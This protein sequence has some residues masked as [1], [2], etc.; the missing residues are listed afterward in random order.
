MVAGARC[1]PLPHQL[2]RAS[3]PTPAHWKPAAC[4]E[5]ASP[6]SRLR[7]AG[8]P[9]QVHWKPADWVKGTCPASFVRRAGRGLARFRRVRS[10]RGFAPGRLFFALA[11][12]S[13]ALALPSFAP[14]QPWQSQVLATHVAA[15][16]GAAVLGLPVG[17]AILPPV[18]VPFGVI[19]CHRGQPLQI[20]APYCQPL[21]LGTTA[22]GCS[23]RPPPAVVLVARDRRDPPRCPGP[24]LPS[25]GLP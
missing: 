16:V 17:R 15:E 19:P 22:E 6:A 20:A 24:A 5:G 3:P 12:P 14:A 11:P 23:A 8:V 1:R 25:R 21:D 10:R 2:R 18:E 9:T 4:V 13:V 7:R